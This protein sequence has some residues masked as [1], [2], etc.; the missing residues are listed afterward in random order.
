M[1]F[2]SN[3][4]KIASYLLSAKRD[5]T[6]CAFRVREIYIWIL[7]LPHEATRSWVGY[8]LSL[9]TLAGEMET[10]QVVRDFTSEGCL[11]AQKSCLLQMLIPFPFSLCVHNLIM[12]LM[13]QVFSFISCSFILSFPLEETYISYVV[14]FENFAKSNSP[15]FHFFFKPRNGSLSVDSSNRPRRCIYPK[16]VSVIW[17]PDS[18][19]LSLLGFFLYMML[20][21]TRS[22][23]PGTTDIRKQNDFFKPSSKV[24]QIQHLFT[25]F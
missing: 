11:S 8:S 1:P 16:S 3:Y 5:Q 13:K 7:A 9:D 23:Y 24:N 6:V 10:S 17:V 18:I 15:Y 21:G 4:Y 22:Q 25:L 14:L 2:S 12:K 20:V 19:R